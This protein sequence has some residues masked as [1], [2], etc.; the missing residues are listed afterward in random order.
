MP[1][2]QKQRHNRSALHT[3]FIIGAILIGGG[4]LVSLFTVVALS[5][6]LPSVEQ[7]DTQQMH[8]STK[9]YDRE[10]KVLL[11]EIAAGERRTVIPFDQ[12]PQFLKDATIAAEDEAF[13]QEPAF[14]WRGIVRA[15]VADLLHGRVVQ[16]GS[17]I[18]QQ[19]AKNAFLS[20]EQTV[21]R[22]LKELIL[23]IRLD[24]RYTK[25][26]ILGF[27][28]NEI[29]FGPSAYGV[30]AASETYFGKPAN[31][32]TLAESTT[33][34]ALL[35][36]PSY[37][38]PWG[39]H[40]DE[41]MARQQ[42]ILKKL[43]DLGKIDKQQLDAALAT[44]LVFQ[45]QGRGIK[46]PH[47]VM[48]VQDY[49]LKKYGEDLVRS[50]GL[51]VTTT[52]DWKLQQEAEQAV[53][54]GAAQNE[55][56]YQGTN[57]ALVA[58]D[59]KTGQVLALVGSRD[60]FDTKHEGNFNVATQGLRQPGSSL[61]PF[62]Y[63]TAFG[64]GYTPE[65]VVF[66]VPTEFVP[67]NPACPPNPDYSAT[68][69]STCFHPQNFDEKFRG[70]VNLRTALAQSIN[71]PAVEV[72]YL[73]GLDDT[74]TTLKN[75]GITTLSD[76]SRYG[77]SLTLGGGEVH[78]DELVGAYATLAQDGVRHDQALVLEVRDATGAI[79][80]S[81]HDRTSV[82][83]DPQYARTVNDILSD[84]DTRAGLFGNS[85]NL[86]VFPDHDV[87]LKTGTTNDYRDAWS[88]G[89]TPSLAVGVWAGNNDNTPMQRHG[90]SILAAVPIWHAFMAQAL[91]D[92]PTETFNRPAPIQTPT[93]PMLSGQ[94]LINN[95]IHTILYYVDR[96]DP[97][98]PAPAAPA[99]DP[100]FLNWELATQ[101]WVRA[102]GIPV[103]TAGGGA[104][105]N[106]PHASAP[107]MITMNQPVVGSFVGKTISLDAQINS[108]SPIVLVVVYCN[109]VEVARW[110]GN[111]GTAY[112]LVDA[113]SPNNI[114]QQNLVEVSATNQDNL[115]ARTGVIVYE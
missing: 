46:A 104:V 75:F 94:Y 26:E 3:T 18:T 99:N 34:A 61:K 35:R 9:I 27:Y 50:G 4:L 36:A 70:P 17:T 28:L 114:A 78:L 20:P 101:L 65:T 22:K 85:L 76:R 90:S 38:S 62:T 91:K 48:A 43:F 113:F 12:I 86:T 74:L 6:N 115:T 2:H 55:K 102:N 31:N 80:E 93:K 95:E 112:R 87:A 23:A 84:S 88:L 57:A 89:Y 54:E 105:A 33:L 71:I 42:F 63:L 100:Q 41:L 30:E 7:L 83:T 11:Y 66:D 1:K 13:Y 67:N 24:R 60:Y 77:L 97:L 108:L 81:Y 47:F 29:P 59:P 103:V 82:V 92:V 107:P 73:A 10:G 32:L 21:T 69:N 19:L 106:T 14:D 79:L 109:G 16:G 49:L 58:E 111:F 64:K 15:L 68:G 5:R 51:V 52:L 98:G 53:S 72:L 110:G 44:K 8:Q 25:D 96:N 56:L 39:S 40:V 37:Y 45:P